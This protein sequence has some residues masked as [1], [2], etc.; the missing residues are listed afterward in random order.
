MSLDLPPNFWDTVSMPMSEEEKKERNRIN[1]ETYRNKHRQRVRENGLKYYYA[2][3]EKI[4]KREKEKRQRDPEYRASIQKRKNKDKQA[5]YE[6]QRRARKRNNDYEVYSL[7]QVLSLYGDVCHICNE[8]IDLT[9][10]RNCKGQNWEF[11]LHI[12][13]VVAIANGG[14]DTLDNVR[15]A[16][17]KCNIDKGIS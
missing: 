11:G 17:A 7:S 13:H 3:K 8:E 2:N 10:P 14:P 16:H 15:P 9:A 5:G 1:N 12:D 4:V 6:R